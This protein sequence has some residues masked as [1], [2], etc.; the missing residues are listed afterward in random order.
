MEAARIDRAMKAIES[1]QDLN[2][3]ALLLAGLV[4]GLFRERGFGPVVVGGSTIEFYTDGACVSGST[5]FCWTGAR[6]PTPNDRGQIM[7]QIPGIE[8]KG[9]RSWKFDSLWIDLLGDLES[10]GKKPFSSLRTPTGEVV[11]LSVEELLAE[12][13]FAARKWA[14]GNQSSE[15]CARK[16]LSV[17]LSGSIPCDWD[18]SRRIASLPAYDC[19]AELEA[20]REE[21]LAQL[22]HSA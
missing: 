18:E 2:G 14:G 8:R 6:S 7:S 4:S 5:D 16:L 21:V 20:M 10:Y 15:D 3:K 19:A 13:V 22:P 11:M 12:R 9:M 1:E 17:I